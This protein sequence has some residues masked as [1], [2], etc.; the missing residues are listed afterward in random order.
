MKNPL[1]VLAVAVVV[2]AASSPTVLADHCCGGKKAPKE[3]G[4]KG[5]TATPDTE[6][7]V[8]VHG[9]ALTRQDLYVFETAIHADQLRVY[10]FD[11]K[12][13]ALP[14]SKLK[15]EAKVVPE[16]TRKLVVRLKP[17][18]VKRGGPQAYLAG[19][20]GM[21]LPAAKGSS[22]EVT[23]RGLGSDRKGTATYKVPLAETPV[24]H[25][26]CPMHPKQRA[27][28]PGRCEKCKMA[29]KRS[30]QTAPKK[31]AGTK[32]SYGCPMHPKVT[33]DKPGKCPDCGMSLKKLKQ[34]AKASYVCPMHP[35]VTSDKPGRCSDCGMSLKKRKAAEEEKG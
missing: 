22:L 14:V 23:L 20:H 10:L 29:L 24:V 6:A 11:A 32:A 13:K 9:G 8:P 35:K 30:V 27:E 33:S 5:A 1:L 19:K 31:K 21:A 4:D 17:V 7:T 15:G 2:I 3:Q 34:A 12:G 25:Y 16:G 18:R 26:A 28:D